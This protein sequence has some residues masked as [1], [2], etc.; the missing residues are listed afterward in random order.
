MDIL[1]HAGAH[2]TDNDTLMVSMKNNIPAL[3]RCH[4]AVPD[5]VLCR[6][7]LR[8]AMRQI[9]GAQFTDELRDMLYD[10]ICGAQPP[11]TQAMVLSVP[12]LFA[13]PTQ[14]VGQGVF[15]PKRSK[16]C[17]APLRCSKTI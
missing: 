15:S 6:R 12:M 14:S 9:E 10:S 4:V 5:P 3:D 13:P 2:P 8:Q 17:A 7:T 11:D 1:L 16:N